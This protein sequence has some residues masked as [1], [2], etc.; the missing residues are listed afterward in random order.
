MSAVPYTLGALQ[1]DAASG[2]SYRVRRPQPEQPTRCLIL[3]HGVGS[4]ETNLLDLATGVDPST[5]VVLVR[6]PLQLGAQQYAWFR[7]AFTANGPQIVPEEAES[8]RQALIRLV[9]ALQQRHGVTT[10]HTVIAGFSQGGIMSA[11]VALSAPESVC[12]FGLLSG[13]ILPELEPRLASRERLAGL[14][15]FIAHGTHD[16]KLPVHWA[17]RSDAWLT[18]LGV[19]HALQLYP[20]DHGISADM[21]ADFVAWVASLG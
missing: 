21:H 2:L 19:P 3:L 14:R 11:S 10:T 17:E 15:A 20:V 9:Q 5:L 18:E 4:N 8:S 6:G 13:R 12:G 16:T 7:V 1:M